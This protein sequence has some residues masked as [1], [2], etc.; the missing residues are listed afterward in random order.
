MNITHQM[1]ELGKKMR[2]TQKIDFNKIIKLLVKVI[3][4]KKGGFSKEELEE[5]AGDLL[6]LSLELLED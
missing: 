3:K 6:L 4:F 2:T 5:L 1:Q